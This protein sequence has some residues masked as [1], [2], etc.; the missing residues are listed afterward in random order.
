VTPGHPLIVPK[1]RA[2][3]LDSLDEPNG[4][5]VFEIAMRLA[6]AVRELLL[7]AAAESPAILWKEYR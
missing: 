3:Y 7:P 1:H 6:A 5:W 4:G 2:T